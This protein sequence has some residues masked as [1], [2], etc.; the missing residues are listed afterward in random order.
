MDHMELNLKPFGST[1]IRSVF[2][3]ESSNLRALLGQA[4][5]RI[6]TYIY[7]YCNISNIRFSKP[8]C[9]DKQSIYTYIYIYNIYINECIHPDVYIYINPYV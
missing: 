2:G 9:S 3:A 1:Q 5:L 8:I 6:S 7:I 4:A